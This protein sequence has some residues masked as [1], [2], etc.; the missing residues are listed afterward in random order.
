MSKIYFELEKRLFLTSSQLDR[1]ID[2]STKTL[3]PGY[4]DIVLENF[5]TQLIPGV[6]SIKTAEQRYN[7]ISIR[8][9]CNVKKCGKRFQIYCLKEEIKKGKDLI[10]VASCEN[11]VC[12][13]SG[14]APRMRNITGAKRDLLKEKLKEKSVGEFYR[15][16]VKGDKE[17]DLKKGITT[18]PNKN[19]IRI[20]R[21]EMLKSNDKHSDPVIDVLLRAESDD[22]GYINL[23]TGPFRCTLMSEAQV[24]TAI[25]VAKRQSEFKL[26]RLH[27]DATGSI[28]AKNKKDNPEMMLYF[29][30]FP[31]KISEEN[32]N[33]LCFN[34]AEFISESQTSFDIE[35]FLRT[36]INNIKKHQSGPSL[37]LVH[38]IVVDWSWAE[39]NAVIEAFN[40]MTVK[41]Y[42]QKCFE[43]MINTDDISMHGFVTLLE[44][45][46]HLTKNMLVDVKKHFNEY[47]DQRFVCRM[48]GNLFDCKTWVD[49]KTMIYNLIQI[50]VTPKNTTNVQDAI[51][52]FEGYEY[53]W[54]K[55]ETHVISADEN[56]FKKT[57][58]K[59]IY[60]DSAFYQVIS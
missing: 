57:D 36:V 14:E 50:F 28:L 44:C 38:E 42:I 48:L 3:L 12:D 54:M 22:K 60:K 46:S 2:Y 23:S 5:A 10:W 4:A 11:K 31:I 27:F 15:A 39:I 58:V 19:T 35:I 32:K 7:R 8:F 16:A 40:N 37:Q 1:A 21:H 30:I 53:E 43:L 18:V 47:Q 34:L 45:S 9:T 26:R 33:H 20:L 25:K 24:T 51:K 29:L 6:Y 59:Q 52:T 17:E 13:H 55:L 41:Q 49:A 56:H